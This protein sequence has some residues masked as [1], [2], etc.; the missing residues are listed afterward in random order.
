LQPVFPALMMINQNLHTL[1]K[2]LTIIGLPGL[3]PYEQI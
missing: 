2:L 1:A 3:S